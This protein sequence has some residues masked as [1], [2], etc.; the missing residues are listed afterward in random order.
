MR[1]S[2]QFLLFVLRIEHVIAVDN[3]HCYIC[4]SVKLKH[5][6]SAVNSCF[7]TPLTCK[8]PSTATTRPDLRSVQ[9]LSLPSPF[10]LLLLLEYFE[11]AISQAACIPSTN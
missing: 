7:A 8:N 10:V 4:S 11:E 6:L 9:S 2:Q 5:S 1:D 3:C